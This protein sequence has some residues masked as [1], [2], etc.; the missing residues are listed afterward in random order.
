MTRGVAIR[1]TMGL[2]IVGLLLLF[3]ISMFGCSTVTYTGKDGVT[4]KYT[5]FLAG[6]DGIR[7][8][9]GDKAFAEINKQTIDTELLRTVLGL[10]VAVPK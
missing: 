3:F 9:L 10:L 7:V 4:V 5:R 6:A 1:G 8:Q 2:C